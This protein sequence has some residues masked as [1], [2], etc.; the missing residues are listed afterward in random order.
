VDDGSSATVTFKS[1]FYYNDANHAANIAIAEDLL[2]KITG[3]SIKLNMTKDKT[4]IAPSIFDEMDEPPAV[5]ARP[6]PIADN[7]LVDEALEMFEGEV[8]D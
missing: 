4:S 1:A 5:E 3:K 2:A 8:V 7:S 6:E